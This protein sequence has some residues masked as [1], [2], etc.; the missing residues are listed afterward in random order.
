[1]KKIILAFLFCNLLN[2]QEFQLLSSSDNIEIY[3]KIKMIDDTGKKNNKYLIELKYSNISD[4]DFFYESYPK[5]SKYDSD[6][7]NF[8]FV[9]FHNVAF[10]ST[11]GV[12]LKG[13]RT[14]LSH[15]GN[16]IFMLKSKK[17]YTNSSTFRMEKG[18][19]PNISFVQH[20]H[21]IFKTDI[22][23]YL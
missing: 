7:F 8:G 1:M 20:S 22:L 6:N 3:Y 17:I 21:V 15:K 5:Q 23:S 11:D 13:D 19:E 14:N 10:L 9:D 2:A 4:Q 12:N 18:T 16:P